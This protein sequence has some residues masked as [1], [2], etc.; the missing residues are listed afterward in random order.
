MGSDY[1]RQS[2]RTGHF[3]HDSAINIYLK[4]II[5]TI[6]IIIIIRIIIINLLEISRCCVYTRE[7]Y[8]KSFV[9]M[10]IYI[11][12]YMHTLWCSVKRLVI[13]VYSY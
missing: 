3:P 8:T 9:C 11:Y 2:S 10:Y 4:K 7:S 12:T 1:T 6:I 5:I 13:P